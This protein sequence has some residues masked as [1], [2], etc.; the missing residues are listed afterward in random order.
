MTLTWCGILMRS[1]VKVACQTIDNNIVYFD[2]NTVF[3]FQ[4]NRS[5]SFL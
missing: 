5:F 4:D 2:V 1:T 3:G